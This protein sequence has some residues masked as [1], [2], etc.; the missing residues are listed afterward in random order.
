M[1]MAADKEPVAIGTQGELT[2]I[3]PEA[4]PRTKWPTIAG[5]CLI[6]AMILFVMTAY[7]L[8]YSA[9]HAGDPGGEGDVE[10]K[11]YE[12]YEGGDRPLPNVTVSIE[13]TNLSTTTNEAGYYRFDDVPTGIHKIR[14]EKPGFR[15]VV[16]KAIV[17]STDNLE[18][19]DLKSNNFTF[20]MVS[21][22][23]LQLYSFERRIDELQYPLANGT[24]GIKVL[25]ETGAALPGVTLNY[26]SMDYDLPGIGPGA[27]LPQTDT[28]GEIL[29]NTTPGVFMLNLSRPGYITV[30]QEVLIS[31]GNHSDI[32]LTMM[33]GSGEVTTGL[34]RTVRLSGVVKT[35]EGEPVKD[36]L[37]QIEGTNISTTTDI[38]GEYVLDSVPVGLRTLTM[39]RVGYS[40]LN[41]EIVFES[42]RTF[43]YEISILGDKLY[44]NSERTLTTLYNCSLVYVVVSIFL[45]AGGVLAFKRKSYGVALFASFFGLGAA[46]SFILMYTVCI[47][48]ILCGAALLMIYYTRREFK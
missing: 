23:G 27:S 31:P 6:V 44:D 2:V 39:T 36:V 13:K 18:I 20:P 22:A 17:Y 34:G 26:T 38:S 16:L 45:L 25:N 9:E 42:N 14:Y 46:V 33:S 1:M 30:F 10:G 8:Y 7:N 4:P 15:V 29:L 21:R 11:I 24:L 5:V 41:T 12:R 37:V 48:A 3:E 43:D 35:A 19:N 40:A 47:A 28:N 32:T